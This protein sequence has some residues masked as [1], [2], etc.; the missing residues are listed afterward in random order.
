MRCSIQLS[1]RAVNT[2]R[3][4]SFRGGKDRQASFPT[5]CG[6][7]K[8][9]QKKKSAPADSSVLPLPRRCAD[10][11]PPGLFLNCFWKRHPFA[12]APGPTSLALRCW[13]SGGV[14]HRP[15][16]RPRPRPGRIELFSATSQD[17]LSTIRLSSTPIEAR[18][19]RFPCPDGL[20]AASE[21]T[22]VRSH[23]S[24]FRC[25]PCGGHLSTPRFVTRR[26]RSVEVSWRPFA[27]QRLG[28]H[29]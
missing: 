27:R 19:S 6:S 23:P 17:C 5:K 9:P 28:T 13:S 18:T 12:E 20:L 2:E 21:E 3:S 24:D 8:L 11:D 1:Y 16:L 15:S 29:F 25:P 22:T 14:P 10:A 4:R 7:T 26:P